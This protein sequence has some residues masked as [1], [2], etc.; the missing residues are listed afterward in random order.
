[1]RICETEL[2]NIITRITEGTNELKQ[3][4]QENNNICEPAL[5]RIETLVK[6]LRSYKDKEK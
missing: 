6:I 1:M 5:I 3:K 4:H 2:N